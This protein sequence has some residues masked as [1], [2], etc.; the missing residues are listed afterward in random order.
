MS[1]PQSKKTSAIPGLA[2]LLL[3]LTGLASLGL[4]GFA[5]FY[6]SLMPASFSLLAGAI[7][8]GFIVH[9]SFR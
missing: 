3:F 7:S 8:F 1:N 2:L 4:A 9:V 5:A 6:E